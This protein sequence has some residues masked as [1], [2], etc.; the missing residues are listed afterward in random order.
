MSSTSTRCVDRLAILR[1]LPVFPTVAL[2]LIRLLEGEGGADLHVIA[3]L[4]GRDPALSG[5]VLRQANSSLFARRRGVA[6]LVSA[7]SLLGSDYA[8]RIAMNA[9]CRGL[10]APALGRAELRQCWEH[11]VSTAVLAATLAPEFDQ[12]P[13]VAYMAGLLHDIGALALLSVYPDR[14]TEAVRLRSEEGVSL[15]DAEMRAFGVN[16]CTVGSWLVEEWRLPTDL[17][18][19]VTLH[20]DQ[21]PFER[22]LVGLISTASILASLNEKHPIERLRWESS[23]D[24]LAT[25]PIDR[26]CSRRLVDQAIEL[27]AIEIA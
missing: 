23:D 6:D 16:H 20:H 11:C 5:E 1:N 3:R 19:V 22:S 10:V 27:I 2:E 18:H 9:A 24:Y 15:L 17:G 25:L 7:V 14:Y 12:T 13:A 26:E 21:R 8:C 4:L